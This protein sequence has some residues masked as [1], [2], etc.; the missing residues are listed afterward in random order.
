M[1]MRYFFLLSL[2]MLLF[3]PTQAGQAPA[4]SV[5]IPSVAGAHPADK[6]AEMEAMTEKRWQRRLVN[7]LEKL[8]TRQLAK[9]GRDARSHSWLV[10]LLLSIFLG[11]LGIDRFYLGYTGWGLV[12]L[13]SGGLFGIMYILDIILIATFILRPKRGSYGG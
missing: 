8:E 12:K 9:E 2:L 13:F 7:K 5:T 4:S 11:V 10:A 6:W 1:N 3:A